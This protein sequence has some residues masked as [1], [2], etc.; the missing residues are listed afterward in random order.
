MTP[1]T[2][3]IQ[4][5][6]GT[7]TDATE[8]PR[9]ELSERE[10]NNSTATTPPSLRISVGKIVMPQLEAGETTASGKTTATFVGQTLQEAEGNLKREPQIQIFIKSVPLG[11]SGSVVLYVKLRVTSSASL[12][13]II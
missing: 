13:L 5:T 7:T 6:G 12:T 10:Y 4:T 11:A 2:G 9:Q 8:S 1:Q 3:A